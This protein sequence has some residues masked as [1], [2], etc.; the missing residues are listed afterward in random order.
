MPSLTTTSFHV[1]RHPS[2]ALALPL[3]VALCACGSD[4]GDQELSAAGEEGRK[5]FNS[6]GCSGCHGGDGGGGSGPSFV[7]LL[8][9]EIELESGETIVVDEAYLRESITDPGAKRHEGYSLR[10]PDN[11]LDDSEIDAVIA[12]ITDLSTD[13]TGTTGSTG[14]T[15]GSAP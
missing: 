4:G 9:S 10:M 8:G 15:E 7:G 5:V 11:D 12:F 3:L 6:N 13:T 14:S 2:L 1:K